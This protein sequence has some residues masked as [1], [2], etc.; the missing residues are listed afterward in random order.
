MYHCGRGIVYQP[1]DKKELNWEQ[2]GVRSGAGV[3]NSGVSQE[4]SGSS[5]T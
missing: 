1:H 3:R 5:E 4:S 2:G